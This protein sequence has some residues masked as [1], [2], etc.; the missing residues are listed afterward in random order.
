MKVTIIAKAS[1]DLTI[2]AGDF[3]CRRIGDNWTIQL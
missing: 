3:S 1:T 2:S